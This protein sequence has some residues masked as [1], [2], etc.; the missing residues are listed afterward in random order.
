MQ[1]SARDP[2]KDE[3]SIMSDVSITE[4]LSSSA[5]VAPSDAMTCSSN[6]S[7]PGPI[8]ERNELGAADTAPGDIQSTPK[9]GAA[10]EPKDT[11]M[12]DLS[13]SKEMPP[14]LDDMPLPL[15]EV[16]SNNA[17]DM[18]TSKMH[19][20]PDLRGLADDPKLS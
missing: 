18:V 2:G 19:D 5:S 16:P 20:A 17:L 8:D 15:E 4:A 7:L 12:V 9:L 6:S 13:P 11:P 3:D 14:P 10:D 1:S